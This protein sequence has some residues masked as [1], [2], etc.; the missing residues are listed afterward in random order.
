MMSA[1]EDYVSLVS[2]FCCSGCMTK[3]SSVAALITSKHILH[4]TVYFSITNHDKGKQTGNEIIFSVFSGFQENV[5]NG[6]HVPQEKFP[7]SYIT[8]LVPTKF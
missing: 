8:P 7:V 6:L 5:C 3:L 1:K 4:C 2:V